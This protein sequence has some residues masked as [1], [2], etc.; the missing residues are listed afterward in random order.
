MENKPKKQRSYL[1]LFIRR[2]LS[3]KEDKAPEEETIASIA[4]PISG[5]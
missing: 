3:M 5:S 2:L 4:E 1:N